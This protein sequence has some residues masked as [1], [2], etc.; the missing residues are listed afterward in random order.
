VQSMVCNLMCTL[1][2]TYV[3]SNNGQVITNPNTA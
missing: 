1:Q 2:K 3:L